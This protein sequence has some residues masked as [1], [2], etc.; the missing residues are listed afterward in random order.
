MTEGKEYVRDLKEK[1]GVKTDRELANIAGVQTRTISVW[2]YLDGKPGLMARAALE[3]A[4]KSR[5]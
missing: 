1:L 4:I 5:T 3:A 2:K